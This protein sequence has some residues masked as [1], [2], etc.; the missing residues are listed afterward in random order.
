MRCSQLYAIFALEFFL[1]ARKP[2]LIL[3][4]T[5]RWSVE[6]LS[7]EWCILYTVNPLF[8]DHHVIQLLSISIRICVC[9]Q[10]S[11]S[12]LK[13]RVDAMHTIFNKEVFYVFAISVWCVMTCEFMVYTLPSC[14]LRSPPRIRTLCFGTERTRHDRSSY[15]SMT[16]CSYAMLVGLLHDI[17]VGFGLPWKVATNIR[18]VIFSIL[19]EDLVACGLNSIPTP[20]IVLLPVL[21][22]ADTYVNVCRIYVICSMLYRI[23]VLVHLLRQYGRLLL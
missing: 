18:D 6:I 1:F 13:S 9:P 12:F 5:I 4:G 10:L 20:L 3:N 21:F 2:S 17:R 16:S 7:N 8:V 22:K 11:S 19:F 23:Y 14:V 15:K